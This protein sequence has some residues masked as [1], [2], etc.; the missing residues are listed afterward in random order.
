[1]GP[2]VQKRVEDEVFVDMD[3][4]APKEHPTVLVPGSNAQNLEKSSPINR[5]IE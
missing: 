5:L 4:E 1:M 3:E 2:L